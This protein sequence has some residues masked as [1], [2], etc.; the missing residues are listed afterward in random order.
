MGT[1]LRELGYEVT[2]LD[3]DRC[4]HP[5]ILVNI[6][7]WDYR[8]KY[9]P[10]YFSVIAAGVPCNEYSPA[11]TVGHRRLDCAER[12]VEK[13]LEIIKYFDPTIWWIENPRM[14]LLK[15]REVV[16]GIPFIDVTI[17][18]LKIGVTKK[19]LAFAAATH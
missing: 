13:T 8:S 15:E 16:R 5:D 4:R 2:S 1:R 17:V 6:L 11:K 7:D 18:S 9:P 19:Q 10:G 14:G 3:I 12:L